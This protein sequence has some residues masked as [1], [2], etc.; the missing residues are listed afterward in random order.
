MID[1]PTRLSFTVEVPKHVAGV[2]RVE[3]RFFAK[4]GGCEFTFY[5]MVEDPKSVEESWQRM[6]E[7]LAKVLTKQH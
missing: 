4:D 7:Q 1:R 5:Q 3:L 6:F 2:T